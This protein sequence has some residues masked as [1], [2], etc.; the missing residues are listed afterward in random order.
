GVSA[1]VTGPYCVADDALAVILAKR[2]MLRIYQGLIGV[3]VI[4]GLPDLVGVF[5]AFLASFAADV[6]GRSVTRIAEALDRIQRL[7]SVAGLRVFPQIV[8]VLQFPC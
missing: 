7:Q 2:R 6:M 1:L 5:V 3:T 4:A 8:L